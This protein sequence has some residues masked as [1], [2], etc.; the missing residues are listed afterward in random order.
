ME[1][2]LA[3]SPDDL[4]VRGAMVVGMDHQVQDHWLT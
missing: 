2:C 3:A 4:N 1:Y